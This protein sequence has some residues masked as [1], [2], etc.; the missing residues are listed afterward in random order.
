MTAFWLSHW[1]GQYVKSHESADAGYYI[2]IY[3]AFAGAGL[4][5]S[6]A[7]TWFDLNLTLSLLL[8]NMIDRVLFMKLIPSSS[9]SL[10]QDMLSVLVKYVREVDDC[11]IYLFFPRTDLSLER[12]HP[13]LSCIN[14][15]R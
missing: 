3:A 7:L 6:Y 10:H 5:V 13:P 12:R 15:R 4:L 14:P 11:I 9:I 8:T 1:A 2:G